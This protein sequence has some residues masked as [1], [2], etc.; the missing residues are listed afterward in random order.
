MKKRTLSKILTIQYL[1]EHHYVLKK[2]IQTIGLEL[3]CTAQAIFYHGKKLGFVFL[4]N[5][6]KIGVPNTS[7]TKFTKGEKPW[8]YKIKGYKISNKPNPQ[9]RGE[10]HWNWK[11]N[12]SDRY[13]VEY[14]IWRKN[15]YERDNY[16]CQQCNKIGGKLNAHHIKEWCNYKELR[17]D[18][19]NGITLCLSCHKKTHNY[20][21]RIKR[22][23][24]GT[25]KIA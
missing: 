9:P 17:F 14:T 25:L 2:N 10:N 15:V 5:K 18:I 16:T 6:L 24:G 11:G 3:N 1:T 19:N 21:N 8:N 7:S 20:G 23:D 22:N 12:G 4:S 13:K